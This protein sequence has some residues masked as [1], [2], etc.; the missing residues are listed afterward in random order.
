MAIFVSYESETYKFISA[1]QLSNNN[2]IL[3]IDYLV[4]SLKSYNLWNK[5]KAVYPFVGGTAFTHKWN[6][7]NPIDSDNA[8]RLTFGSGVT[9]SNNGVLPDATYNSITNTNI[10]PQTDLIFNNTHLS[11]YNRTTSSLN[12]YSEIGNINTYDVNYMLNLSVRWYNAAASTQ[13][14]SVYPIGTSSVDGLGLTISSKI[15]SN[16][17]KL[18]IRGLQQGL[19]I[20]GGLGLP[21]DLQLFSSFYGAVKRVT[22]KECAFASIGDGLT[23]TDALNLYNIV[24]QYQ[25]LLN[26]QV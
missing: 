18:Y 14:S 7:I 23:D 9:H 6:L 20:G 25:T 24:Q 15:D 17:L 2:Q 19:S 12:Y 26:R 16:T 1:S 8:F 11:Y 22:D 21:N 5:M 10:N 3:A 4:Y 13:Y